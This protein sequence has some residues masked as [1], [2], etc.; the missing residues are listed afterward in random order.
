MQERVNPIV[1]FAVE[2]RVTM[3]MAV[4][5]VLVVGWISLNRLPLEYLPTFS[6]SSISVRASYPSSSPEEIERLIT[7][8]LEDSLGTINGIETMSASASSSQ[9]SVRLTFVD[10]TD[11]ELAA[12][13]VR[14]R[15][16]RVR[17]L[18]PEQV[19]RVSIRRFQSTDIPVLRFHMSAP[20]PQERLFDFA[21]N[22]IQRR[23]ERLEGVAEVDI[24]GL[25]TALVQIDADPA[26]MRAHGVSI[27]RLAA[28]IRADNR[29]VSAGHIQEGS[30]KLLVRA[31]GEFQ[32]I[33]EIRRLPLEEAGLSLGDVADVSYVF[34][35]QESWN[36]L[37]GTEALTIRIN[38]VGTANLLAVVDAVRIEL[39]AIQAEPG[40]EG[41]SV[42]IY[43]DASVDVRKGLAQLRDAGLFGGLLAIFAVLLFLRRLRTTLL[44]AIAIPVSVIGTF[45][46]MYFL[47]QAN[48]SDI[49]LNVV[50]LA[51]LMLA[52]GMLVDNSIVVIESIYRHKSE[53]G[54]DART[55][56]MRGASEVALPVLASTAT[57]LCVFL[58][59]IFLGEGGWMQ[60]SLANIATT[61][62]IVMAASLVVAMTVVPMVAAR[63]LGAE[64]PRAA[65]GRLT[66]GYTRV[67][68][69]MLGLRARFGVLFDL[70]FIGAMIGLLVGANHMFGS[71]GRQFSMGGGEER[72]V[73]INIDVPR[74]YSLAQTRALF[75][76][77][78]AVIDARRDA[79]DVK[80]ITYSYDRGTGRARGGYGRSRSMEIH[81]KDEEESTST[82]ADVRDQVRELLPKRAGA[83]L[84]IGQGRRHGRSSGVEVELA[85][86]DMSVLELLSTRLAEQLA[87]DP[88]FKD[89]DT[90]LE[91]GDQEIHVTVRGDRILQ[92]GLSSQ[93]VAQTI[94]SAL[95]SRATSRFQTA[96]RE[97][98]IQLQYREEDRAT[99]EQLK[100]MP[101]FG[102]SQL[103]LAALAD[104]SFVDGP[105]SIERENHRSKV[106]VTANLAD[107]SGSW[108]AMSSVSQAMASF[109]MPPGYT[110]SF[111]RWNRYQQRDQQMFD[112]TLW[113][114]LALV[115]MLM[116][117]LFE[118]F[119][120]PLT[121]MF[122]VP[123]A[124]LGVAVVMKLTEQPLDSMAQIGVIILFGVVVNNAIVLMDRIGQLRRSGLDRTA[125]ILEAG[126]NRLRPILITAATTIAGLT[127]MVA[128]IVL[129]QYFGPIEG[130]AGTW[131]PIGLVIMGGLAASTFLTLLII[132][133]VYSLVDDLAMFFA[134]V[135]T[136]GRRRPA[137]TVTEIR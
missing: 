113:F 130:R 135:V 15:I 51:G 55:A 100:N 80:N 42:H 74:Q 89:V 124:L 88:T 67:L 69:A 120:Q 117:A 112:W 82:V 24:R 119:A 71:I 44:V 91:S 111:G 12:V 73:T 103:P 38:K 104:F 58:P 64:R 4:L 47:R 9:G 2:R 106:T 52:L 54:E 110:W 59:I 13:D 6:S 126:R 136:A 65:G 1:R 92:A 7:R 46:L 122:S 49:T 131:A 8:P 34:P 23:L 25:R 118:S 63:L 56:A 94:T 28:R 127:P 115:Y 109:Q 99:L 37:D 33:D 125:A 62:S 17:H 83:N 21:E 43:R 129:P 68:G 95:S 116:A 36:Y 75:D 81:L 87:T 66:R 128:P 3:A 29:N 18:L 31:V 35:R 121:I 86:D 20:W 133:T 39:D 5:G 41:L 72:Q 53:L 123:F 10:G 57:T 61:V 45:V 70:A 85:G 78:Y 98:D 105:R 19:E 22:V 84:R 132:P 40:S 114:A 26:R 77:L 11:M 60:T 50:S 30:Q 97:I 134:R 102:D 108:M 107:P 48:L 14:D 32:S 27:R 101:V 137:A 93:T 90:S 76:E 79:L 16:D 96:D